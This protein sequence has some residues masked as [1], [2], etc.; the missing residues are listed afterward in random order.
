VTVNVSEEPPQLPSPFDAFASV[1]Q[2]NR[3]GAEPISVTI[4]GSAAAAT[5][6]VS[7]QTAPSS[8][9]VTDGAGS[10]MAMLDTVP[11]PL[12]GGPKP[13]TQLSQTDLSTNPSKV[14][15]WQIDPD[16]NQVMGAPVESTS[17]R[18]SFRIGP[19]QPGSFSS[20]EEVLQDLAKKDPA[21]A[22][23]L[24][25]LIDEQFGGQWPPPPPDSPPP[26]AT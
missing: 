11:V 2:A 24:R 5:A 9:V 18:S 21:A 20:L 23:H 14:T 25:K 6:G 17:T 4:P 15:I 10:Y 19:G 3:G 13:L 16:T 7:G 8:I 22:E 12:P 26:P 1:L